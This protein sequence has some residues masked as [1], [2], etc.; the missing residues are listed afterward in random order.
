MACIEESAASLLKD[1][2]SGGIVT[3]ELDRQESEIGCC[4]TENEEIQ[5][6]SRVM[7]R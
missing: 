3:E 5:Q 1:R 6:L 7:S 2:L 4:R